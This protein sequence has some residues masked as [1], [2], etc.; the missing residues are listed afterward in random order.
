M[1]V[2]GEL[3]EYR[4][5]GRKLPSAVNESP[6]LYKMQIFAP[7]DTT[8]KSR[9]WYYL[10]KF[11]KM[12]K[13]TGEIVSIT[14]TFHK[15]ND[16]VK[17]FGI[18]LRYNSRFGTHN[19]YREYRDTSIC[20]AVTKCYHDMAGQHRVRAHNIDII[21]VKVVKAKNVKRTYIKQYLD[22]NLK[23]PMLHR[24]N[25]KLHKPEVSTKRPTTVF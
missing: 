17:N 3:K 15:G 25:H 21:R 7:N 20:S 4:I 22:K 6:K 5:V 12:K 1:K 8:A 19:M 11:R 16:C 18:W 24:V 14:R 9:F 13:S 23:F 2:S 10:S